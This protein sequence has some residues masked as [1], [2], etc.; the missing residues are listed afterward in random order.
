M[1]IAVILL[2]YLNFF[3]LAI[4]SKLT[5]NNTNIALLLLNTTFFSARL[6]HPVLVSCVHSLE[7]GEWADRSLISHP[8]RWPVV[9]RNIWLIHFGGSLIVNG[10]HLIGFVRQNLMIQTSF[11]SPTENSL[12]MRNARRMKF[13]FYLFCYYYYHYFYY[14]YYYYYYYPYY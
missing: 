11:L 3:N 9:N 13:S 1:H 12:S 8:G 10:Q 14:Y 7:P 6:T 2:H 4:N 5:S